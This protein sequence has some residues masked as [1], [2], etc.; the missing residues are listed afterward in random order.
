MKK[1]YSG[2]S[3][4]IAL[5]QEGIQSGKTIFLTV[6]AETGKP[7]KDSLNVNLANIALSYNSTSKKYE[8]SI[9][10]HADT[11]QQ[12][13]RLYFF[14]SDTSIDD[15][16]QPEDAQ[17]VSPTSELAIELVP[18][19]Y[20]ID[21]VISV[22]SKLDE[23]YKI[24]VDNYVKQNRSAIRDMLNAAQGDLEAQTSLY[25]TERI[26]TDEKKDYYFD[27]FRLHLWQFAVNYPPLNELLDFQIKYGDVEIV[28][29]DLKMFVHDRMTGI[30]EFLPVPNATQ[31]LYSLLLQNLSGAAAGI[32]FAGTVERIPSFFRATYKTGIIYE[33]SDPREKEMVKQAVCKKALQKILPIVDPGIRQPSRS[34]SIDGVSSSRSYGGTQM[35]QM[36]AQEEEQ[37]VH[38]IKKRYG[39]NFEMVII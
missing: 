27:R 8:K 10:I 30:I 6:F 9:T 32:L 7:V 26:I 2:H 31:G 24:A 23:T 18:T 3:Q 35:L 25:M 34:E 4:T 39:K 11:P 14:S 1:I 28:K 29:I 36:F 19:Q 5:D 12:Y 21:S 22:D 16:Y 37:F 17:L 15:Q 20:F 38:Y 13:V 33:G